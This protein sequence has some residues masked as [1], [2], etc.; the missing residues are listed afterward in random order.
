MGV[1]AGASAGSRW[2][3]SSPRRS[4]GRAALTGGRGRGRS[5]VPLTRIP[6]FPLASNPRACFLFVFFFVCGLLAFPFAVCH[7]HG[8]H[9]FF[10]ACRLSRPRVCVCACVWP[11][12]SPLHSP[13]F[14]CTRVGVTHGEIG[15]AGVRRVIRPL[16]SS[17]LSH[18][19]SSSRRRLH[20]SPLPPLP[21]P[22]AEGLADD[23]ARPSPL[24]VNDGEKKE[25]SYGRGWCGVACL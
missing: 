20:A 24:R 5:A 25:G 7:R 11:P 15:S 18:F 14:Q 4:N 22:R 13:L 6:A 19:V 23:S 16:F 10:G 12:L 9:R 17:F 2:D 8:C 1:C 21:S 3:R